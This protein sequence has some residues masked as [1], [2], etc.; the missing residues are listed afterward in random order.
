M[1]AIGEIVTGTAYGT[2]LLLIG[3]GYHSK[4]TFRLAQK[5][6][7][8]MTTFSQLSCNTVGMRRIYQ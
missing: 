6:T 5:K 4:D 7:I 8:K 2:Q 3:L 1:K